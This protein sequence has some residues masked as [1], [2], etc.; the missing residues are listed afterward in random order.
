MN[1]KRMRNEWMREER[2]GRR[3]GQ[4]GELWRERNERGDLQEEGWVREG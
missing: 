4:G 3:E 2:G 1:E